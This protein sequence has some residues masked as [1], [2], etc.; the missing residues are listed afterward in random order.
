MLYVYH[1]CC[2]ESRHRF[3]IR[4]KAQPHIEATF[5]GSYLPSRLTFCDIKGGEKVDGTE[6]SLCFASVQ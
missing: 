4:S 3:E 1:Q 6:A 2:G 5:P